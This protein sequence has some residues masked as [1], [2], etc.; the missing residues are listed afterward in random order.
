MCSSNSSCTDIKEEKS[1]VKETRKAHKSFTKRSNTLP[2]SKLE[3]ACFIARRRKQL[4]NLFIRSP[5]YTP[6]HHS[7][8]LTQVLRDNQ[9]GDH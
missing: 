2:E 6:P 8:E 7:P 3:G 4:E 5:F 1:S 9:R